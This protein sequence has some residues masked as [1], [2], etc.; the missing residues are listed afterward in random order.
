MRSFG[1]YALAPDTTQIPLRENETSST[2]PEVHNVS[3]RRQAEPTTATGNVHKNL[4]KFGRVVSEICEH[5]EKQ[6]YS[7]QYFAPLPEAIKIIFQFSIP[8]SGA[9]YYANLHSL[10]NIVATSKLVIFKNKILKTFSLLKVSLPVWSC[11]L[12]VSYQGWRC[13]E[14]CFICGLHPTLSKLYIW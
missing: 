1:C 10:S 8:Y 7:S 5:S 3:Q 9:L 14:M 2:E 13:N 6:T 11:V 4:V 12:L